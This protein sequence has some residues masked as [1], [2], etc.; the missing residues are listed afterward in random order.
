MIYVHTFL[1]LK[2]VNKHVE[3]DWKQVKKRKDWVWKLESVLKT[4]LLKELLN[5]FDDDEDNFLVFK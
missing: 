5:S 3:N 4:D 1:C 2:Y